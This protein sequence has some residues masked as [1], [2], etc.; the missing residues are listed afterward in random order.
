MK[1]FI[2]RVSRD[3]SLNWLVKQFHCRESHF[4]WHYHLEYELV[5]TLGSEGKWFVG[6]YTGDFEHG[7]VMM[8]APHLPHTS[9]IS[10]LL[11]SEQPTTYILWFSH[12]WV[13]NII[14][15]MPELSDLHEVL[16]ESGKGLGFDPE[17]GLAL[18]EPFAAIDQCQ[19]DGQRLIHVLQILQILAQAKQRHTFNK[20][21]V[22]PPNEEDG[23]K[24]SK[25]TRFVEAN[26]DH[27]ITIADVA[28]YLNTSESSVR[29]LFQKH[30]NESFSEHI[31]QYRIGKA[32]ELLINT[33][34][35][36]AMIAERTGFHNL[37]NFNRQFAQVKQQTPREFRRLYEQRA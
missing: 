36:I 34:Q 33:E 19:N 5:L 14:Q 29:R 18:A 31:K 26:Y 25:I 13:S 1:P 3:Q 22:C 28:H 10:R 15:A 17:V 37:S 32:C 2:E 8:A 6:G 30:F 9:I 16:T 20:V 35:P 27:P 23:S 4:E 7:S 21:S 24:A 11:S 12:Q